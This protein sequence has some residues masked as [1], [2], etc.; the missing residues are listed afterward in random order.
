MSTS[1]SQTPIDINLNHL[2]GN[3]LRHSELPDPAEAIVAA[4]FNHGFDQTY[5]DVNETPTELSRDETNKGSIFHSEGREWNKDGEVSWAVLSRWCPACNKEYEEE[6]DKGD[7]RI[8]Y[9][10]AMLRR[11]WIM[12]GDENRTPRGRAE[13]MEVIRQARTRFDSQDY[14]ELRIYNI[15]TKELSYMNKLERALGE[16]MTVNKKTM[17]RAQD[18]IGAFVSEQQSKI[19]PGQAYESAYASNSD[20]ENYLMYGPANYPASNPPSTPTSVSAGKCPSTYLGERRSQPSSLHSSRDS[21][22]STLEERQSREARSNKSGKAHSQPM[23]A[24]SAS[25]I[26]RS[27]SSTRACRQFES[28]LEHCRAPRTKSSVRSF[29]TSNF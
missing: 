14:D 13:A 29:S 19:D 4:R 15:A 2:E 7:S 23:R 6:F 8:L 10:T 24:Q 3:C 16:H 1:S 27:H 18:R 25:E 22:G 9:V 11:R 17:V 26:T 28:D 21:H 12:V 20:P 5:P